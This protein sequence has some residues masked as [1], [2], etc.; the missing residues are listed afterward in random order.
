MAEKSGKIGAV[1]AQS[2]ALTT[3]TNT[4]IGTGDAATTVFY[5]E[6]TL[7]ACENA[8]D[9]TGNTLTNPAGKDV[10]CL[11]DQEPDPA[12]ATTE[13]KTVYNPAG[14]WDWHDVT[15]LSFWLKSNRVSTAFTWAR[16]Y[17]SDGTNESYWNL[18]FAAATWT[19][20]NL[21]LGTPDGKTG[22][23]YCVLTAV[24]SITVNFK[25][26]DTTTFY[27][28]IDMIGLTPQ[29]IAR[30]VTIKVAGTAVAENTYIL[31]PSGT[32]TFNTAP[33]AVAITATYDYYVVIQTTGF[34]NWS[35]DHACDVLETTDYGDSGH[36]TYMAALKGW[37][38]S[39]GRHWLTTE[40]MDGWLA[41]ERIV[42]FFTD[43]SSDPQLRYEG[44]AIITGDSVTSAVD[45][46]VNE[47]LSF[48]GCGILTYVEE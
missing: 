35:F 9:W 2:G 16:L 12:V 34:F 8:T 13:Y 22:A 5:L 40:T 27:K 17:L 38:G 21:L 43:E 6:K 37:T 44:W 33:A 39:A 7:L 15:R 47:S 26:A 32:L 18:A 3:K 28:Q 19:R 41:T 24:T 23:D 31:T 29:G 11:Q 14:T 1:Y 30:S 10:L 42:K 48:Q 25:A 46:L 20:F 4:P 45:T 36:R